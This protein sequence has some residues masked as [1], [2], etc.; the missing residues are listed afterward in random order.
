MKVPTG[1][2]SLRSCKFVS[3]KHTGPRE[4]VQD[5]TGPSN[6]ANV[7]T[8]ALKDSSEI[9]SGENYGRDTIA[10]WL[11]C[12]PWVVGFVL[13]F[14][15]P[16][17]ASLYW[18]FCRFDLVNPP[19]WIGLENYRQL[20]SEIGNGTGFG[21]ALWNTL[22]YS[23][24]S[25]PLSV[26]L[27]VG[28]A[29]L[30]SADVRGQKLY[31]TI[32]FLPAVIPVVAASIL[33]L[34]LLDPESGMINYLL[35]W[36]GV[37]DQN[38]LVQSRS[39]GESETLSAIGTGKLF[40]SKDAIVLMSLWSVG[41]FVVIY[42]AAISDIPASLHE[43]AQLDGANTFR[44]LMHVTIPMLSP[45]IFFNLVM[46]LIRSVQTFASIYVLSEGTGEP[47][48]SLA[49]ISIHLFL[50]AFADLQMGYASAMAW[51][52]FVILLVITALLF[53]TSRHWVH[54]RVAG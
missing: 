15:W 32:V 17:A 11:F 1:Q 3:R 4:F 43:A 53:R 29:V 28:L 24:V 52:L 48:A 16:F 9:A 40:G 54:Y 44:R 34:W 13:L 22:Y 41:N 33:W 21:L 19:E 20:G 7:Q 10:G 18:S 47:G 14:A 38:W 45:V 30:L 50:S 36:I 2:N 26:V 25:V 27:G 42:L 31:R 49:L 6:E 5:V 51:I 39:I 37:P 46:G 23:L 35:S 12:S 8:A